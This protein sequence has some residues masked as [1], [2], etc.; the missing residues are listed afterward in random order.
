M[1]LTKAP[2]GNQATMSKPASI[3]P[4]PTT[5]SVVITLEQLASETKVSPRDARML[6]RLAAKQAKEYPNLSREHVA[7]QPWQWAPESK[8]LCEARR[9]LKARE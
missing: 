4:T 2:T 5:P 9:V 6:L 1:T 3:N 8:A 7:R